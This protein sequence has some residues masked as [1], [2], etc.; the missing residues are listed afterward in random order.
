MEIKQKIKREDLNS[1]GYKS[2]IS[3][4]KGTIIFRK[5][6]VSQDNCLN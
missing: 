3:I 1:A 4:C 2:H 6:K 5:H